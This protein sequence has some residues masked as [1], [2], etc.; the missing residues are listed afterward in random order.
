MYFN[1]QNFGVPMKKLSLTLLLIIFSATITY[2]CFTETIEFTEKE[3]SL[4]SQELGPLKLFKD[5]HGFYIIKNGIVHEVQNAFCEPFLQTLSNFELKMF[6]GRYKRKMR[7]LT[8]EELN[9]IDW[10]NLIE[11]SGQEKKF[12]ISQLFARGKIAINRMSD[13]QYILR[14]KS[15]LD[16]GNWKKDL[17]SDFCIATVYFGVTIGGLAL[18]VGALALSPV[19]VPS[20]VGTILVMPPIFGAPFAA[21]YVAQFIDP[22]DVSP[23]TKNTSPQNANEQIAQ[24]LSTTTVQETPE[25]NQAPVPQIYC[26]KKLNFYTP[27]FA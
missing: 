15:G 4:F 22:D 17:L 11:I 6:L 12:I 20:I 5:E 2:S 10:D 7:P 16:G 19:V 21:T 13:G 14:S 25:S 18:V 8:T 9:H 1:N 3:I 27:E 26:I 23:K 24:H